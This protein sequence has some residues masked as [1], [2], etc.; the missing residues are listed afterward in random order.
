MRRA[1]LTVWYSYAVIRVVPRVERGEFINVGVILF[2]RTA[3]YLDARIEFDPERLR[4]LAPDA[5]PAGIER[6]LRCFETICAG[7]DEGGPLAALPPSE[8]FHWLT[9]PRSTVIQTSPVHVGVTDDPR[10]TL[11]D[12][13]AGLVRRPVAS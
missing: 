10:A 9:S 11:D 4:A 5:E 13:V 6:H 8:R 7:S 2:A 1:S 3:G 12:L